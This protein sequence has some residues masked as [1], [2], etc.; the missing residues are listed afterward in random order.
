MKK[1]LKRTLTP[2]NIFLQLKAETK[3]DLITEMIDRLAAGGFISDREQALKA[4]LDR[5]DK[6]STGMKHGVAIPHGKTDS[7][8]RL[9][10]AIGLK[11]TGID[12]ESSDKKPAKIF[13]MTISPA[14]RSGPHI[15]FLAEV[16]RILRDATAREKMLAAQDEE[17][18]IKL[19]S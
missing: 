10:V 19:F 7:V 4:V 14:N 11:K 1:L 17:T 6:M 3:I 13:I 8:D 18:I 15:Q 5:E 9:V 16:S 12:F 2:D